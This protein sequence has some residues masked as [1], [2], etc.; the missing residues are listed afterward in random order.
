[1]FHLNCPYSNQHACHSGEKI[2]CVDKACR[3]EQQWCTN[4]KFIQYELLTLISLSNQH[5]SMA[6]KRDDD[7]FG[8]LVSAVATVATT[9]FTCGAR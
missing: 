3:C 7:K 2:E 6:T 9:P 8:V 5:E 1:M 4:A